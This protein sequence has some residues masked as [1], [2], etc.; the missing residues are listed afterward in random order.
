MHISGT[1]YDTLKKKSKKKNKTTTTT[2]IL[3]RL[4]QWNIILSTIGRRKDVFW[5]KHK[6]TYFLKKDNTYQNPTNK[7][8]K[9][10]S[11]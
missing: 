8:K 6:S 2:N 9:S 1:T 4:G 11:K 10:T 3:S 7:E 5:K